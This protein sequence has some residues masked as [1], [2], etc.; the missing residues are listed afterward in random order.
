[1]QLPA[2]RFAKF[3]GLHFVTPKR[4]CA[5]M[6]LTKATELSLSQGPPCEYLFQ[7][8]AKKTLL[9]LELRGFDMMH[10]TIFSDFQRQL[11]FFERLRTFF[12]VTRPCNQPSSIQSPQETWKQQ[13]PYCLYFTL[14]LLY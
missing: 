12:Q 10:G 8:L 5:P 4:T 14:L 6:V 13:Q 7:E 3:L 1:M 9:G 2:S 11:L